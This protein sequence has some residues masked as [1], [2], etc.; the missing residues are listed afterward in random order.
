MKLV[1]ATR[2]VRQAALTGG[3]LCLGAAARAQ[4][5]TITTSPSAMTINT[6]VA[7]FAPTTRT[8]NATNYTITGKAGRTYKITARITTAMPAGVTL[9][10]T[11]TAPTSAIAL[12]PV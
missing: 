8:S 2:V 4:G 3:L 11:M 10:V 5:L 7:G 1:V 9:T 6:A 12:G